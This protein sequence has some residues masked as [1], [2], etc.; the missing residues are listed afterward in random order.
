MCLAVAAVALSTSG[1]SLFVMAGKALFGDPKFPAEFRTATGTDLTDGDDSVVIICTAPHRLTTEFPSLQIDMLD[2]VTRNLETRNVRV[3]PS[4]DVASWFDDHG[5]WGDY[6]E[7]AK[8]FDA[9]F[10]IHI[11]LRE[12]THRVP[13]SPHLLQGTADGQI[14]VHEISAKRAGSSITSKSFRAPVSLVFDRAFRLR[15]PK[16]YPVP[17]ETRSEDLFTQGFLDR[18]AL[19]ISQHFYDYRMSE[20]IH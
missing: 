13:E 12:F 1:C 9:K 10:V 11:V 17:L 4:G 14:S 19:N 5:E 6:S 8:A 15:Y 20:Q 7:L 16:S 3:V 2:R 18:V